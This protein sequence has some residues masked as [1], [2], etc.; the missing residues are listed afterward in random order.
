M[1]KIIKL[2]LVVV[3]ITALSGC[4]QFEQNDFPPGVYLHTNDTL[5]E[6]EALRKMYELQYDFDALY[7]EITEPT[8]DMSREE[9]LFNYIATEEVQE[10]ISALQ[11]IANEVEKIV[12]NDWDILSYQNMSMRL[13]SLND[14]L[15]I[16]YALYDIFES[17]GNLDNIEPFDRLTIDTTRSVRL[18]T[19][20]IRRELEILGEIL[21]H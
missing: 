21:G 20:D 14:L 11:S 7:L 3:L 1:F 6:N 4:S 19:E 17:N 10:K 18:N 16:H 13:S 12:E 15:L 5:I 9:L 8:L 2:L